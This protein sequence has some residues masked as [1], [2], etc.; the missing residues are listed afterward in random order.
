MR[1]TILLRP[2]LA[3]LASTLLA[4]A[5]YGLN[6]VGA[7]RAARQSDTQATQGSLYA[8]D[9]S[10]KGAG[11]CPLKHTDVRAEVSGFISR[12]TVTQEFENPFTD[13][14]EAVYVFPL[15]QA[16]AVDDMTMEVGG[17]TIKGRT[18]RR[19]EAQAAYR[20]ARER[21]HVA[22]LLNQERP[23]VFTQSVANILPGQGVKVR[24][25]YVE[26]LKYE[27]GTYEW[28]FPMVVGQRYVP[29][30]TA[31]A[32]GIN[33]PVMPDGV[34]AGHDISVEV[35]IDAGVPLEGVASVTHAIEVERRGAAGAVVRL[36]DAA[37]IPNK[38]FVLKYDVAGGR[39]EDA[40]LTHAAAGRGGYLALILQPPD[41]VAPAEITPKELVFVL[42]T[43]GSMSG[44]PIEKAKETMRLALEGLNPQDTFNLITFSGDTY[45]LFKEPVPATPQNLSKAQ[46]FLASRSGGGGTEMMKAIRAALDPSDSSGHVRVVCFMT[47]G[48]V[49]NESEIIGEVQRHPNARVFSMGF[50]TSPNRYLLD[51]MA[52]YGRGEVEYVSEGDDGADAARRFHERVRSPL[53]TDLSVEWA[54]LPVADLYPKRVPDLFSAK[55][56]ILVGRYAG[57]ARGVVRLRGKM[58]G[59]EFAREVAVELPAV[60]PSHDVLAT[61]WAR[62]RVDELMGQ[63]M[64]PGNA[65]KTLQEEVARLGL[66]YRLMTQFTSFVAVEERV[67]TDGGEPRRVDVPVEAPPVAQNG[68]GGSVDYSRPFSAPSA[69]FTGGVAETVTVTAQASVVE[70]SSAACY[71]NVETHAV[72]ELPF[73]GRSIHSLA[74]FMPGAVAV[75]GATAPGDFSFNG[76]RPRS[77]G[78]VVD[79]V[80]AN[81]GIKPGGRSPGASASGSAP[82]LTAGVGANGLAQVAATQEFT[83]R[84]FDVEPEYGRGTGAQLSV[85]TRGGTNALHGSLFGSFGDEALDANDWFANSLG[86]GRSPRRLADY[87]G[88]LGGPL[89]RDRLFF[90]GSY[91]G[92]RRRQPAFAFTEVPTLASRLA[93]SGA[94]RPF[95]EAFPLPTGAARA[96]GFAEFAEGFSTP[97]GLDSFS[98]RLDGSGERLS[99]N[100]RYAVADSEADVR[101]AGG[102]SLNTLSRTRTLAQTLT[103]V[104]SYTATTTSVWTLRA[105]YSRVSARG[106]RLLDTFGGAVVPGAETQAGALLSKEGGGFVFDLGGRGAALGSA[107]E[108]TN[109]QR[110]VNLVGSLDHV[111]GTHTLKFGADYR[112]LSPVI[113]APATERTVYFESVAGALSGEAARDGL[114][115]RASEGR[116]VF[117]NLSAY[118]QDEWKRTTRLTLT[119]GLRWELSPAPHA[120]GGQRPPAFTQVE[121]AARLSFAA[122]DAPLWETTYF[123]FEPRAG[124]AYDPAGNGKTVLR[125]GVAL[126]YDTGV[127]EAGH[128]FYDSHPFLAG[129]A[130]FGVPF[131]PAGPSVAP[132]ARLGVPVSVFDPHLKLPYTLRW[133]GSVERALGS[134]HSVSATY[135]GAAGRRLLLTRTLLDPSP[136]FSLARVTTNGGRSD[137]HSAR[138]QFTRRLSEGLQAMASYTLAKSIDDFSEDAPS[139]ALLRGDAERGASDFDA[140]HVVSGYA[141]YDLPTPFGR[142]AWNALSRRWALDALF[143]ARSGKPVNVVYGFPVAY[144][145]AFLRPDLLTGVPFYVNDPAAAGGRR[146]NPAAF[147]VPGSPRQGTLGRNALRGFP[148]YQLDLA[149]RRQFDFNERVNLQVRAEALNLLNHPNFDDPAAT[150]TFLGATPG[151]AATLRLDPYFDRSVSA[152]GTGE[153][154]GQAGGFGPPYTSGG[155]RTVQVSLK[156]TF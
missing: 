103:G 72:M 65:D 97:A 142:G 105:N 104:F 119:Y 46:E 143:N 125:A 145:F 126:L 88:T 101:G 82:G 131:S 51:K 52:E 75:G 47:D 93:A 64:R 61:L 71:V 43:S 7:A 26:T 37:T 58:A 49:G 87:G 106:S 36:K 109:R 6:N 27:A 1:R 124:L 5:F 10:G 114:F 148:F 79:G 107:A 147:F 22:S 33:P 129:G 41:R 155:A 136:D 24:I 150:L 60:Q 16:A 110:Q 40:L 120:G 18:M 83:V 96:D 8:V 35:S 78:Y 25:S 117:H 42:D 2:A 39:V 56:V 121:D 62:R 95:L 102:T 122:A 89:K 92:Q 123:N 28:S 139:R 91:E 146:L 55:P 118:A 98:F 19:E 70:T 81:V 130:V 84:T 54:G 59:M 63:S 76:Q 94:V 48:W 66:D 32:A 154:A 21:G 141:S 112:R 31:D 17:R 116:P 11:A 138:F 86:R 3:A 9:P 57:A 20:E 30:G 137:Y 29:A 12:V 45:V 23:N 128:A 113:G 73:K 156:L 151:D 80:S 90:F 111:S 85:T 108:V 133:H 50:G 44:F 69:G 135:V 14:I 100:A 153:W 4:F 53:L 13:K 144:G 68:G 140:R 38:D 127:E 152:R 99:V 134:R 149:L 77:N 115:T 15:P 67:V 132:G 34:R 74:A